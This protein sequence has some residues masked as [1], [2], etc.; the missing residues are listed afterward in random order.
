MNFLRQFLALLR[1]NL[2]GEGARLGAVLTIVVG[3]TCTVAV[4]VSLLAMGTGAHQQAIGDVH[5]DEAVVQAQGA[6]GS[7]DS[8][9]TRDEMVALR[10]L[11]GIDRDKDGEPRID[12]LVVV[13]FEGHR[14]GS[15]RRVFFPLLGISDAQFELRPPARLTA[16]RIFQPGLH[17]IITTNACVTQFDGFDLGAKREVR[18]VDWL[19]VGHYDQGQSL[20]CIVLTDAETL[21]SLFRRNGFNRINVRLKSPG[22]FAA[23]DHALEA[24]PAL[25]LEAK[26]ARAQVEADM[27]QFT[28]LL[29]FVSYFI[30]AIMGIG[31]TFGAVNSLYSI[32]DARRRELATLRAIGFGSGAIVSATLIES[33]LLALPGAL[34]GAA[35]AWLLF[36]NMAVSPGGFPFRLD[37]TPRLVEIG[38]AWALAMGFVGGLLPA[39]RAARVPVTT[40]LRAI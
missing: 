2:E 22:D 1:M 14:R 23:F 18:G 32:V 28:G 19:V 21:M 37:V 25:K 29:N 24:N 35:C 9:I 27:K 36:H 34:L 12:G 30:G 11:P 33:T 26:P 31:A 3:V 39:L 8:N 6:Q 40:A 7:F 20:Q 13:P 38:I 4:L 5:D 10:D 15:G 17:E 16:G